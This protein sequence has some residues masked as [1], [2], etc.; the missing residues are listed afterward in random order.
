M[1]RE[2]VGV[3]STYP[4]CIPNRRE[5]FSVHGMRKR[6]EGVDLSVADVCYIRTSGLIPVGDFPVPDCL[7]EILFMRR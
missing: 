1:M 6:V 4:F 3:F 7:F 5:T 2:A